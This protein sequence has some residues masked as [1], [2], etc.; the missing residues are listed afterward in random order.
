MSYVMCDRCWVILQPGDWPF[1]PHGRGM[2]HVIGDEM[3]QVIENNGTP[4]PIRFR[5]K[6]ELA[7]HLKQHKREP[8]VRHQPLPGTDKS[9]HTSDWSK[10]IDP[11]TLENARVLLR[12]GG[13]R[14]ADTLPEPVPLERSVREL[15]ET[16]TV[17]HEE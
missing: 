13:I 17:R 16:F 6:A 9:P 15:P 3:D 10:G 2:N 4:T 14:S 7:R 1:C 11:Q 5:S 8:F 12:R